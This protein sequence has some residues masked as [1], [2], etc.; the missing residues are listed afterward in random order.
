MTKNRFEVEFLA[1]GVGLDRVGCGIGVDGVGT[2][3]IVVVSGPAR[4]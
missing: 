1:F 2:G 3:G 4:K